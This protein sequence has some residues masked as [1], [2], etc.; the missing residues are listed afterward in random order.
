[1]FDPYTALALP[2]EAI[3]DRRVSKSLLIENGTSAARDRRRINEGI[4]E[5]R[6]LAALK[7]ATVGVAA[8][9]GAEREYLEI[10]VLR[11][12][13]RGAPAGDR[14]TEIVHRAVPYP[15]VLIAWRDGTPEVSLANKRRSLNDSGSAVIDGEIVTVRIGDNVPVEVVEAFR[16]S[17]ALTRQPRDSLHALYLGW[18]DSLQAF[19]AAGIT[20]SFSLP[21][22]RTEAVGRETALREWQLL[23]ARIAKLWVAATKERQIARR[24]EMNIEL[25]C[26]RDKRDEALARLLETPR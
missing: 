26:L 19:D 2:T 1:M 24:A 16:D 17:L 25:S 7:P 4:E 11:L 23:D 5:L 8:Y 20:G 10:A 21:M 9:R 3:V 15:V 14:L 12:T 6:W 18:M 22:S 13:L